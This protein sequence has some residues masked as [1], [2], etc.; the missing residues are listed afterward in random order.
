LLKSIEEAET[1]TEPKHRQRQ[2]I[3]G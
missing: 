1:T 3:Y 2:H